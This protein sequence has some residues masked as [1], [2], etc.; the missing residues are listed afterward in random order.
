MRGVEDEGIERRV[1]RVEE[2][3]WEF[4]PFAESCIC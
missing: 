2:G 4:E 1:Q 3:R